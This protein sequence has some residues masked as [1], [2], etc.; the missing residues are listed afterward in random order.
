MG[1]RGG[2]RLRR[3]RPS[4]DVPSLDVTLLALQHIACEPPAAF[5]DELRSRGLDL[6]RVELDEGEALPDWREFD[7]TDRHGRPDGRLRGGRASLAR[8]SEKRAIGEAARAGH[9]VWGVCLGAQLLAGAL[10]A[11]RLPGARAPRSGLLRRRADAGGRRRPGLP[12]RARQRSRRSS[13]TAT[14]STS[15][16]GATLLAS[17]PA[18]PQPGVRLRARLRAPVP[19]RGVARAGGGVGRGAGL[20]R[21]PRGDHGARARSTASSAR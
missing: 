16:T 10:G 7:G 8:R 19:P 18:Y 17:S 13:G 14:P 12:R 20:R 2:A 11:A 5:E 9:P 6:V 3:A 15:P 1:D 4:R 21:E